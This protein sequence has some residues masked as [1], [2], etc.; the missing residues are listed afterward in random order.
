[1][2]YSDYGAF[3]YRNGE[4]RR[5]KED[6]AVFASDEETFGCESEC[7]PS[8]LRI[9]VS[10]M[11]ARND[12]EER[13]WVQHIHHGVIGAGCVR[14]AC[15]KQG[16]PSIYELADDG[17]IREVKY[18]EDSIEDYQEFMY[19]YGVIRF[20]H[21]GYKFVFSSGHPY[22]AEMTEPDGTEWRCEY[23]YQFGAGFED[24]D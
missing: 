6:V 20:E 2:A 7:V 3:V 1:M 15:Y 21:K 4:R 14:V 17:E 16:R 22:V 10:L 18:G 9:F 19:E 12:G 11:K 5:D 23:D 13:T 8:G 24:D